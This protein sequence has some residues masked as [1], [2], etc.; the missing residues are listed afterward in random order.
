M[1]ILPV[2]IVVAF[3]LRLEIR[4]CKAFNFFFLKVVLA[5]VIPFHKIL[6]SAC[7]FLQ[8]SALSPGS[9]CCGSEPTK[10]D[11]L[12]LNPKTPAL[13]NFGVRV[14]ELRGA[15]S[16]TSGCTLS[17]F[18]VRALKLRGACS[19]TLGCVFSNFGVRSL[20]LWGARSW[21]LGCALSNLG[22]R[23][24]ELLGAFQSPRRP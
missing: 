19:R 15:C 2:L 1:P 23:A 14:L 7:Y 4:S 21:N 22:V 11:H 6:E 9:T 12:P 10:I 13:S 24:L 20:E 16:R 17:N 5:V 3:V 18:G 8:K